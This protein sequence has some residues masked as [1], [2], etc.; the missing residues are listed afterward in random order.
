MPCW[1]MV[2]EIWYFIWLAR[3]TVNSWRLYVC[4]VGRV[5]VTN[6]DKTALSPLHF[7]LITLSDGLYL[8]PFQALPYYLVPRCIYHSSQERK[9]LIVI[10]M[11]NLL[12]VENLVITVTPDMTWSTNMWRHIT[13]Q[14]LSCYDASC[15]H[16]NM[17]NVSMLTLA[18][19][20]SDRL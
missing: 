5:K 15:T 13:Y 7:G 9:Q 3:L 8:F 19:Q 2:E 12:E 10:L 16:I 17:L 18:F 20:H 6:N 1:R 14:T 4:S 11:E